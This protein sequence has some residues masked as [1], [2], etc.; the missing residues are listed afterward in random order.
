MR[1]TRTR[2]FAESTEP[3]KNNKQVSEQQLNQFKDNAQTML[4]EEKWWFVASTVRKAWKVLTS[5]SRICP[6]NG[7]TRAC[8]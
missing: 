1:P 6:N 3:A 4:T 2:C 5:Y 7:G 8:K